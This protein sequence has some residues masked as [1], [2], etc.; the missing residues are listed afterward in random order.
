MKYLIAYLILGITALLMLYDIAST[1]PNKPKLRDYQLDVYNDTIY[2][3]D[4]NKRI[5]MFT[6]TDSSEIGKIILNDNQ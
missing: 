2:M 6:Y 1:K 5:G 4:G 3:F